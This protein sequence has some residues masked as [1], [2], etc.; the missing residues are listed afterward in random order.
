MHISF[1]STGRRLLPAVV[2]FLLGI[3]MLIGAF[4]YRQFEH[5]TSSWPK[6]DAKIENTWIDSH[7]KSKRRSSGSSISRKEH[8]TEYIAY[9]SCS[10]TFNDKRYTSKRLSVGRSRSQNTADSYL[11]SYPKGQNIQV[12]VDPK[13][14]NRIRKH[15]GPTNK[16]YYIAG[17]GVLC[18]ITGGF[19][20]F[21]HARQR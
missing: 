1:W 4:A 10:Y 17:F 21:G 11:R 20:V 9:I 3:G 2:S 19:A 8:Y 7:R 13:S 14:P 18:L 12:Y 6:V 5:E 16:P 15:V